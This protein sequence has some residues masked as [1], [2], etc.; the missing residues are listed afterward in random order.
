MRC[1]AL[2]HPSRNLPIIFGFIIILPSLLFCVFLFSEC[3]RLFCLWNN[4]VRRREQ[5]TEQGVSESVYESFYL[6]L[7][8]IFSFPVP[9][10]MVLRSAAFSVIEHKANMTTEN[11]N[12]AFGTIANTPFSKHSFFRNE[13]KVFRFWYFIAS[14][15]PS[16][17]QKLC[18]HEWWQFES[19]GMST[20]GFE[21]TLKAPTDTYFF[22][23][24]F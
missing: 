9:F 24:L 13:K 4:I 17:R 1:L 16:H 22:Q 12:P 2:S 11:N 7:L 23:S 20:D 19:L 14:F 6:S 5:A 10:M 8:F 3:W 21:M 15:F 18:S